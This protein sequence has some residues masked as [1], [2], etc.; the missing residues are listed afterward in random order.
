ME[1][2][3]HLMVDLLPL[4]AEDD[5]L[6]GWHAVPL[7]LGFVSVPITFRIWLDLPETEISRPSENPHHWNGRRTFLL[8]I[9]RPLRIR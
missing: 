8:S 7:P 4:A 6:I 1:L 2:Y 3:T 9:D 5:A